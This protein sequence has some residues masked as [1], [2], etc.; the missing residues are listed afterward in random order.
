MSVSARRN[1]ACRFCSAPRRSRI[2]PSCGV[3]S[4]A[5][6]A[7]KRTPPSLGSTL[8]SEPTP[9]RNSAIAASSTVTTGSSTWW[10]VRRFTRVIGLYVRSPATA[11][12]LAESTERPASV[13]RTCIDVVTDV[14][15]HRA[16]TSL[17]HGVVE[18]GLRRGRRQAAEVDAQGRGAPRHTAAGQGHQDGVEDPHADDQADQDGQQPP[19][20]RGLG[21]GLGGQDGQRGLPCAP[22]RPPVRR[23]RMRRSPL[24]LSYVLR[25]RDLR[26]RVRPA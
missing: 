18:L 14:H 4:S 8:T 25:G 22:H 24:G 1:A 12:V 23:A 5:P 15:R 13:G 26:R 17:G 20:G 10:P 6:P 21:G 2:R 7:S 16:A 3:T 9:S 19:L 11:S